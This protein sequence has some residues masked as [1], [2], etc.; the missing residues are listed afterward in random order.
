M[1]TT[2]CRPDMVRKSI[3]IFRTLK[4]C[5]YLPKG[6]KNTQAMLLGAVKGVAKW[7]DIANY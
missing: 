6:K 2:F 7:R 3:K 4:N 5:N 1:E